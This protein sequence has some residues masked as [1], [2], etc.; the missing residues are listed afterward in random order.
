MN[1]CQPIKIVKLYAEENLHFVLFCLF[2]Y[3][4]VDAKT[5]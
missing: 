3:Q 5:V 4:P 2:L 1:D